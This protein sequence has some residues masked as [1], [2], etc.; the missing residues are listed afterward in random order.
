MAV[1]SLRACL[2]MDS[3]LDSHLMI[4]LDTNLSTHA[5]IH[6]CI[7]P[8]IHPIHTHHTGNKYSR[9][10]SLS[11]SHTHTPLS[12]CELSA[13]RALQRGEETPKP[14]LIESR[15]PRRERK[16]THWM[17]GLNK[18]ERTRARSLSLSL[19]NGGDLHNDDDNANANAKM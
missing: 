19:S 2:G 6:P 15:Q 7:Y 8:C 17:D 5:S 4:L 13:S 3:S 9:S 14:L 11:L 18:R 12:V 1:T 16:S 10:L